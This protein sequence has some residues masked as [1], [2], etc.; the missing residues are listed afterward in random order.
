MRCLLYFFSAAAEDENVQKKGIVCVVRVSPKCTRILLDDSSS[1]K[2]P[3]LL[4]VIPVRV[5][6]IHISGDKSSLPAKFA[7]LFPQMWDAMSQCIRVRTRYY[8]GACRMVSE[9]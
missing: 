5:D 9:S 7:R 1:V 8:T 3:L 6:A 4:K 2:V